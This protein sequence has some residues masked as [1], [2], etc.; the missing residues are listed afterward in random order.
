[1]HVC[2]RGLL[3]MKSLVPFGEA[4]PCLIQYI[5]ASA[6]GVGGPFNLDLFSRHRC[7]AGA[8][9]N[10]WVSPYYIP[11][12]NN[13]LPP[14]SLSALIIPPLLPP[15]YSS[16]TQCVGIEVYNPL[17]ISFSLLCCMTPSRN[18]T[19]TIYCLHE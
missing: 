19:F 1:M 9:G 11:H 15:P 2:V 7:V 18:H 17:P 5:H 3:G 10:P 16:A 4:L 14:P 6:S 13:S 8:K 12:M